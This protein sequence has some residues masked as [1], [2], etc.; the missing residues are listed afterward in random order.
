MGW[1]NLKQQ[2]LCSMGCRLWSLMQLPSAWELSWGRSAKKITQETGRWYWPGAGSSEFIPTC[3]SFLHSPVELPHSMAAGFQ[4]SGSLPM[5]K[6]GTTSLLLCSLGQSPRSGG[7][8]T[9]STSRCR[10]SLCILG[11][12]KLLVASYERQ[13]PHAEWFSVQCLHFY[14]RIYF[15]LICSATC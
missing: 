1:L 8:K 5:P 10:R 14:W 7:G 15:I 9:R 2:F 4:E 3:S 13:S 6:S 11:W 12:E